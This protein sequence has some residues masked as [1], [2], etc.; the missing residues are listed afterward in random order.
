MMNAI[1]I[2]SIVFAILFYQRISKQAEARAKQLLDDLQ[3]QNNDLQAL[4][5][6]VEDSNRQLTQSLASVETSRNELADAHEELHRLGELKDALTGM[7]V[8]DLKNPLQAVLG[9]ATLP[10][11][12]A[13]LQ[14]IRHAGQQMAT[15]VSNLLDVQKYETH[16]LNLQS[17]PVPALE[18]LQAAT[19]QTDYLA[20]QKHIGF[21]VQ[22][23]ADLVVEGD[24][25]LLERVCINLLTN[26]IKY[27]PNGDTLVLEAIHDGEQ[28]AL[29]R[30]TDHGRGIAPDQLE[31]VF[32]KYAQV[33]GGRSMGK[34]RSTGLGLTFCKLTVEAHGGAI[35]AH[36]A[37]GQFTTIEFRLPKARLLNHA[38]SNGRPPDRVASSDLTRELRHRYAPTLAALAACEPHEI[39]HI[40]DLLDGI[41]DGTP[42]L[43]AWRAAVER[44]A[45]AGDTVRYRQL[46]A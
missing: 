29:F 10:P 38:T 18:I 44:A 26:A 23:P 46:L 1:T 43:L 8:H 41:D 16:A 30:I 32:D 17:E 14:V 34:L 36:S 22:A 11:D 35:R 27:A 3:T 40:F 6:Q 19:L 33:D 42:A 9:L 12:A 4:Q 21:D 37:E 5:G 20:Q 31:K 28:G 39:S 13:R 7:V 15:L 25:D 45:L 2:S 24:R